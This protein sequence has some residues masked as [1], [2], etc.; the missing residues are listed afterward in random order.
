MALRTGQWPY[1]LDNGLA[2]WTT[3][4]RTG[5]EQ[6]NFLFKFRSLYNLDKIIE[7]M[8]SKANVKERTAMVMILSACRATGGANANANGAR[9]VALIH[10][11]SFARWA[12][13]IAFKWLSRWLMFEPSC[14]LRSQKGRQSQ[15]NSRKAS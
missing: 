4:L 14:C 10:G 3:A 9:A 12:L 15:N 13:E 11:G 2:D 7:V 6:L 8:I 1:G 5:V